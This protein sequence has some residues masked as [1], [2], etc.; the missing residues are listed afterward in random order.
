MEVKAGCIKIF[1]RDPVGEAELKDLNR[2]RSYLRDVAT[3]HGVPFAKTVE[4]ACSRV[5]RYYSARSKYNDRQ[6]Q[7]QRKSLDLA[8]VPGSGPVMAELRRKSG[9]IAGLWW[10]CMALDANE[11][12]AH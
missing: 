9:P 6:S 12:I 11:K 5:V 3:R 8:A 2:Q 1:R 4:A 7:L 10:D